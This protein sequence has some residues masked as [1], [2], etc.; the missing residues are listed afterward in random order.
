MLSTSLPLV[1]VKTNVGT[2]AVFAL[3]GSSEVLIGE[4]PAMGGKRAIYDV[5]SGS[6]SSLASKLKALEKRD[7]AYHAAVQAEEDD[8]NE[9]CERELALGL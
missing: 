7:T 1:T 3:V 5:M 2:T 4:S 8:F 9:R 6:G